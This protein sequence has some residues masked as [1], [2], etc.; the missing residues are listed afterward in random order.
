MKEKIGEVFSIVKDNKAIAGC[1]ISK[2][3]YSNLN[4]I[5]YFSLAKETLKK[6]YNEYFPRAKK[7]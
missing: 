2:C 3:I 6:E 5:N 4:D 1:T 7:K